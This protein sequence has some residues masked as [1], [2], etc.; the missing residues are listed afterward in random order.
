AY[1]HPVQVVPAWW[2]GGGCEG[3]VH[4]GSVFKGGKLA[5]GAGSAACAGTTET[6]RGTD[7]VQAGT[8]RSCPPG[9]AGKIATM[10]PASPTL[11]ERYRPWRHWVEAAYWIALCVVNTAANSYTAIRD[12]S[13]GGLPF[14]AWE[15]VAWEG[16]SAL[17]WLLLV[18]P[19]ALVS[20]RFPFHLDT[21][22]RQLPVHLLASIAVSLAHVVGMVG[23]RMLAYRIQG[24]GYEF[25][26][27][28]REL[29]YEY[30]KDVRTYAGMVVVMSLYRLVLRRMQGEASLL[31]APDEGP[32]VEPLERPERFLVAS[33]AGSSWW[34]PPTWNGCRRRAT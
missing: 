2:G 3:L 27:W 25:G 8:S 21:W 28:P 31:S 30:I 4:G 11:Y 1:A 9:G 5:P 18:W 13:K 32:P 34:R 10:P 14:A 12:V 16:S 24:S 19:V 7:R 20:R 23:L 26:D 22:W 29:F 6:G 17:M 15:V 33:S